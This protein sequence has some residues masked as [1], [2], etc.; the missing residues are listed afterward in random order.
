VP[1]VDLDTVSLADLEVDLEYRVGL[2]VKLE[3]RGGIES[4]VLMARATATNISS[5]AVRLE[6]SGCSLLLEAYQPGG[7]SA[8]P[9]WRQARG[10]TWPNSAIYGCPLPGLSHVLQPGE[11][12]DGGEGVGRFAARVPVAEV[13]GDS[14][15]TGRYSFTAVLHANRDSV[16]IPAGEVVLPTSPFVLRPEISMD[17]FHYSAK[18]APVA[19]SPGAYEV[20]VVVR[21]AG[22]R[23]DLTRYFRRDCPVVLHAYATPEEQRTAPPA[24]LWVY[25]RHCGPEMEPVRL[26]GDQTRVLSNQFAAREVLGDS[27]PSGRYHFTAIVTFGHTRDGGGRR[28][29]LDAGD[30]ELR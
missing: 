2:S 1:Q 22:L 8:S 15:P 14:L 30:I 9:A 3:G 13:Y 6:H 27:L 17:G 7:A 24:P 20:R 4:P 19:G 26:T 29:W 10:G 11:S 16:R 25:P 12:Y 28:V 21:N 18:A 5:R 23:P